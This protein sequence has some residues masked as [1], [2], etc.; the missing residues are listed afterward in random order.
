MFQGLEKK[1][2]KIELIMKTDSYGTKYIS[3]RFDDIIDVV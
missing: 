3:S 1:S 2:D